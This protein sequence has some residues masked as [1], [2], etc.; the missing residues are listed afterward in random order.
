[1]KDVTITIRTTYS[2]D[3]SQLAEEIIDAYDSD[4]EK[5]AEFVGLLDKQFADWDFTQALDR[6]VTR[7]MA[8]GC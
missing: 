1:M 6:L 4:P 2:V 5:V 3:P 8:D 7:L